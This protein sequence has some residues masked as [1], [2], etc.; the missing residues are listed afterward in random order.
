MAN[1]VI[2][3]PI[4]KEREQSIQF[5]D[6]I[7]ITLWRNQKRQQAELS[8]TVLKL[9]PVSMAPWYFYLTLALEDETISFKDTPIK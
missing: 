5:G 9:T 3:I 4:K 7:T 2:T 8:A 6:H 1:Q